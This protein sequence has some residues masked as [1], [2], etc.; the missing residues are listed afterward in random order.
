MVNVFP[1]SRNQL[2]EMALTICF[3]Q[4]RD[5]KVDNLANQVRNFPLF[6]SEQKKRTISVGSKQ[7]LNRFSGKLGTGKK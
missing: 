3:Q 5:S 7:F 6:R 1:K 4:M 2:N